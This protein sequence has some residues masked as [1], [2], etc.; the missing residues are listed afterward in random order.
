MSQILTGKKADGEESWISV[1][2]MMAG[3]MMVF[4]FIA[5]IYAK[6]ADQRAQNVTEVVI[7]WQ[8]TE[9]EIYNAL[10]REFKSDLPKWNAEIEKETLTIR[11]NAPDILFNAGSA[12]LSERFE[13]VLQDFMPRYIG[14]LRHRFDDKIDE[15]R[16]EGHT[17]SEWH[18]DFTEKQAFIENMKLS[19]ARTRTV[20]EYS[21]SLPE[22]SSESRWMTQ[23]VSA[24]GLSSAKLI[25]VDDKENKPRSRRVE[26]TIKTKTKDALFRVLD[27]IS[28]AIEKSFK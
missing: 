21:L 10:Y 24:N 23:K 2:D 15:V 26:F 19:Q 4:L 9:L 1:A 7:E 5:I 8:D 13:S 6:V 17:S 22:L 28:P 14:L 16:I 18:D 20:L 3:L 25:L 27:K 11:F 12:E